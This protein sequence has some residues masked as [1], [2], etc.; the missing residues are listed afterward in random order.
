LFLQDEYQITSKIKSNFG[1]RFYYFI[2]KNGYFYFEPR[3]SVLYNPVSWITFKSAFATA[4]QF[5]HLISRNDITLP[6]DLWYPSTKRINPG[7]SDQYIFGTDFNLLDYNYLFSVEGYYKRMYNLYEFREDAKFELGEP[8][9]ELLTRGEGEAYG[10]EFFLN[11]AKGDLTGWLGYTLSWTRRKFSELNANRIFYPRYDRRHEISFVLTYNLFKSL[12]L[13]LTWSYA[14][15]GGYTLPLG[16]YQFYNVG[17]DNS[18]TVRLNYTERNG[19]RLPDYHKMDLNIAYKFTWL[20]LSSEAYLNIFN[21]YNRKNSFAQYTV[22]EEDPV[23][24]GKKIMK[25]KQ[26]TLFPFFPTFGIKINF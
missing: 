4:H 25:L 6:T 23:N 1:G 2:E 17:L 21:L 9:D 12:S 16:Q 20:T 8:V 11:K 14:T 13:G 22:V 26:I 15:G 10:I 3:I 5:L 18:P 19:Y 7:K 24:P